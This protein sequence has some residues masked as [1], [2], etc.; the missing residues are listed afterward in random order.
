MPNFALQANLNAGNIITSN[1]TSSGDFP[2]CTQSNGIFAPFC[3]PNDGEH[4]V[5]D[6]TYYVTWNPDYYSSNAT[7]TIELRYPSS[8][9]GDSAY[10]S[11]RT[12]NSYGYIPVHMQKHW[13]QGEPSNPLTFYIIELD[14]SSNR[15]AS[16]RQGPTITLQRKPVQHHRPTPP[17]PFNRLALIIGLPVSL[18]VMVLV[19]A[20][21]YFGMRDSRRIGVI[22]DDVEPAVKDHGRR[23]RRRRRHGSGD[24]SRALRKYT[25]YSADEES[26]GDLQRT[27]SVFSH[28]LSKLKSWGV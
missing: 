16:V 8:T 22:M 23:I 19:V 10:T 14:A 12:E 11:D 3:L 24:E 18:A 13:L 20:G 28:D 27:S 25:D 7:I 4:M 9:D 15:R 17:P 1:S 6:A 26:G 2:V 21:L 5:V